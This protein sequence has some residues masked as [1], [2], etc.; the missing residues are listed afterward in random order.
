MF[1]A[2]CTPYLIKKYPQLCYAVGALA[3]LTGPCRLSD[4]K[5]NEA[6]VYR[7]NCTG[8]NVQSDFSGESVYCS[9]FFTG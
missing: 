6:H 7:S 5:S 1:E 8:N 2:A 9:I 4:E 3:L